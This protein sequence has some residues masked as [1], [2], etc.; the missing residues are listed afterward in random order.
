MAF[1][2]L[3]DATFRAVPS[4][5]T[6]TVYTVFAYDLSAGPLVVQTPGIPENR[7]FV[8]PFYDAFTNVF[9]SYGTRTK[10]YGPLNLLLTPPGYDGEIP[11]GL[12]E[13][14]SP[15]LI[16][17]MLGRILVAD[18]DDLP[19]VRAIQDQFVVD[20][21][22]DWLQG[23]HTPLM[24]FAHPEPV[25]QYNFVDSRNDME[26]FWVGAGEIL[27]GAPVPES[28]RDQLASFEPIGLTQAGF[29]MPRDPADR[30]LLLTETAASWKFLADFAADQSQ[31]ETMGVSFFNS[32]GWGWSAAARDKG[33]TG[34]LFYGEQYLLR[35]W[36]NYLYYGALPP[37]EALYPTLY[38]DPQGGPLN[39]DH[40]YTWRM[41]AGIRP[42]RSLGFTSLTLYDMDGYFFDN[43]HN[44]YKIGDRD[45]NL[46][47]DAD[48]S[49]TITI[50][51]TKPDR[52]ANWLPSPAGKNFYL[53]FRIYLPVDAVL[54]GTYV[55][56]PVVRA[57]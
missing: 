15:S 5:N 44:I 41:P 6:D 57:T 35:A 14:R 55:F 40:S 39:G 37:E 47:Y 32:N 13:L 50:S 24:D 45:K 16:G 43:P 46:I 38:R 19:A 52:P 7:Y 23:V 42:V 18:E 26:G 49:L 54:D 8:L 48:G 9:A 3:A 53:M 17:S 36:T 1:R 51:A 56:E 21:L 30:E 12:T 4:P 33:N 27:A 22:E 25:P 28:Q 10:T 20:P 11:Q 34:R 29:T 31:A 2:G